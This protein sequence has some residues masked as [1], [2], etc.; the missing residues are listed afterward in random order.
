SSWAGMTGFFLRIAAKTRTVER[1]KALMISKGPK[2]IQRGSNWLIQFHMAFHTPETF[3]KA[4]GAAPGGAPA[5]AAGLPGKALKARS[6]YET[7]DYINSGI[8]GENKRA[9]F[10][11]EERRPRKALQ[12]FLRV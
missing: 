7:R 1:A 4:A 3:Q 2:E 8:H 5:P 10:P 9:P 6:Y 12:F 11:F